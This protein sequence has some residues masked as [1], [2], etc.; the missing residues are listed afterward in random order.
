MEWTPPF[1]TA[2]QAA[3]T[4]GGSTDDGSSSGDRLGKA[5]VP[6]AG[7]DTRGRVVVS[8]RVSRGKL[9]EAVL[10][11]A[12]QL[13]AMEACCSAHHWGQRFQDLGIEVRLIH[14]KFVRPYVKSA[15]NNARDAEAIC[16]AAQRPHMRFVPIKSIEQQDIQG[17]CQTNPI[18]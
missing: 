11:L 10:Q 15:K 3:V 6:A 12:P 2:K 7:I 17:H 1:R 13:V 9:V 4:T 5:G 18:W 14:A 16:E 8:R